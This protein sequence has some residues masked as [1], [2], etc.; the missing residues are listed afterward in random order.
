MS[1]RPCFNT[2]QV[3][4]IASL[5]QSA[6]IVAKIQQAK[7]SD[8]KSAVQTLDEIETKAYEIIE[9]LSN[10][11]NR[12]MDEVYESKQWAQ[13]DE[14]DYLIIENMRKDGGSFAKALAE[15]L[16]QADGPNLQ[17]LVENFQ[18]IITD[19]APKN[20]NKKKGD[21]EQSG[22]E[23]LKKNVENTN[24][25]NKRQPSKSKAQ[26]QGQQDET[27]GSERGKIEAGEFDLEEGINEARK[28]L[29]AND[30]K[31]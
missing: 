17:L 22:D 12:V 25:R 15:A 9:Y 26:G 16:A 30:K 31:S 14:E 5:I 19:Y 2:N 29:K 10:S 13:L 24:G 21:S 8:A 11:G 18:H 1:T 3:M 23:L 4:I 20:T 28:V 27:K 6:K 7:N